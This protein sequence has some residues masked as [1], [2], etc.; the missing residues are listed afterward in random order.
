MHVDDD[1][2]SE[3]DSDGDDPVPLLGQV[4]DRINKT[5]DDEVPNAE[6]TAVVHHDGGIRQL[7]TDKSHVAL[8]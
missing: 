7:I 4:A 1:E 2:I 6:E 5:T 8:H 3:G